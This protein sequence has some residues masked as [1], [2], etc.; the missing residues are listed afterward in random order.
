MNK[1]FKLLIGHDGSD[2]ANAALRDLKKSR[3]TA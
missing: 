1:T 3:V 2:E